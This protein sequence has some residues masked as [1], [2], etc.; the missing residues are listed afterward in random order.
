[1]PVLELGNK[2]NFAEER[3]AV[4]LAVDIQQ[5]NLQGNRDTLYAILGLPDLAASALAEPLLQP[6]LS[7]TLAAIQRRLTNLSHTIHFGILTRYPSTSLHH[8][9]YM[10]RRNMPRPFP[11]IFHPKSKYDEDSRSPVSI[12]DSAF[13]LTLHP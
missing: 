10:N 12:A 5:R 2:P 3:L 1:M 4:T 8:E 11:L 6:I 7:Q 13:L 9:F